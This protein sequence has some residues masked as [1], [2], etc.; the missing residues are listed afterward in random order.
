MLGALLEARRHEPLAAELEQLFVF[1]TNGFSFERF[2]NVMF[3]VFAYFQSLPVHDIG[4]F[5]GQ[6]FMNP[7]APGNIIM[8]PL[9]EQFLA[10]VVQC[11]EGALWKKIEDFPTASSW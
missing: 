9:F 10:E 4:R 8:D 1:L 7:Y 5:Q 3:G 6:A 2:Q 11:G